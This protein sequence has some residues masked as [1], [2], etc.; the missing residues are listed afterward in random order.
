MYFSFWPNPAQDFETVA[1]LC[2]HAESTGWDGIWYADHFM[3]NAEDTS[4]DWPECWTTLTAL[5]CRVPR[6]RIGT[7]VIGNTYRHPAVLAK[8]AATLD[9]ICGGRL[10]LGL[11]AGWQENEHRQYGI[12]FHDVPGRLERLGEACELI[13][14]LFREEKTNFAGRHYTLEDASFEP[15]PVQD[16]LP[17]LVGGGGEKVTLRI[18]A[19]WAQEWNVWGTPETLAHKI[20]VL[21]G[22]CR[23]LGRDP[24]TIRKSAQALLFMSDDAAWLEAMRNRP[25]QMATMIGTPA[26]LRDVV[27]AYADAGVDELI[28]PDFTL[29]E[30]EAKRAAMDRFLLEVAGR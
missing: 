1:G 25:M 24:T 17:L 15:K 5:A 14:R 18:A 12:P 9:H 22:H 27:A 19:Q 28:I 26:E 10:V 16:P 3:P 11:G 29:G 13:T 21:E 6:L 23:D 20:S 8:M 4:A 2:S 30:G 7:L